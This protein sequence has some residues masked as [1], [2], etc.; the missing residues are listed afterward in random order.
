MAHEV[1]R[2]DDEWRKSLSP[3][4]FE[5]TR[6]KGT[7]PAFSGKY[8]DCKDRGVYRCTGAC[9][10]ASAAATSCSAQMPSTILALVG[11]ASWNRSPSRVSRRPRIRVTA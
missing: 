3:E 10:A 4:Q 5:V 7:E 1:S 2:S 11:R 9:T 6:K 8:H